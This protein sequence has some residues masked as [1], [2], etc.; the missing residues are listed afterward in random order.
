MQPIVSAEIERARCLALVNDTHKYLHDL[1]ARCPEE[2]KPGLYR[3]NLMLM[4]LSDR[5]KYGPVLER[6]NG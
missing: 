2:D 1:I 3:A 6:T 4:G 5:V